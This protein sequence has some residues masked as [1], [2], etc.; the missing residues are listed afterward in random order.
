MIQEAKNE[1]G[2]R[3]N[4]GNSNQLL[5]L[6]PPD[7]SVNYQLSGDFTQQQKPNN[8]FANPLHPA[9]EISAPCS[10]SPKIENTKVAINTS[11]PIRP[12]SFYMSIFFS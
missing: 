4:E 5:S 8:D 6:F 1:H 9:P 10:P 7:H 11:Q 2:Q 3:E 12:K